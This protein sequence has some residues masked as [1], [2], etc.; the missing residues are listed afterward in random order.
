MTDGATVIAKLTQL[1]A[2]VCTRC[3]VIMWVLMQITHPLC[4]CEVMAFGYGF[5]SVE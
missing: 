3:D 1:S 2:E 5:L 4:F